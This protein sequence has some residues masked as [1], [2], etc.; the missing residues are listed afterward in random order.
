MRSN[1]P[2]GLPVASLGPSIASIY[3]AKLKLAKSAS[4]AISQS[5]K[6]PD[7][8]AMAKAVR[9]G[10][11]LTIAITNTAGS[12]LGRGLASCHRHP[13]RRWKRASPPP[14][15]SW[16]RP[17]PGSRSSANGPATRRCLQRSANCPGISPA[18]HRLR[19]DGGRRRAS[20]AQFAVHPRPRALGGDR[21]RGGAQIQG[22]LRHACRGLQ[23][24]RGDARAAGAGRQGFSRCWRWPR[25]TSPS[26]RWPR[27][28]TRWPA[29]APRSSSPRTA[30]ARQPRLPFA[31]T[32]HPL[33]DPL[34]LIV[35]FYGFV[36]AFARH[37]GLN[38][39]QPHNLRK[40]TETL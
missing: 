14:R 24:G 26:R 6:S 19:L 35:S 15:P 11:A 8:V 27:P 18:R 10:G 16:R 22:D 1:S 21:Q 9:E 34:A 28:P 23:R 25:G 32:G 4:I 13:L 38:P 37:R 5:G 7:I 33:T 29:R 17:S 30:P 12:P 40:V 3:G 36:E 2:P 31:A 20:S 39:D